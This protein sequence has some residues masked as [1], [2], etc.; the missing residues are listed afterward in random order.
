MQNLMIRPIRTS[1]DLNQART[2]LAQIIES[3]ASG[4]HD[5]EIEVLSTLIEQYEK[6]TIR[7]EA[8]SPV[9][10]IK[11]RMQEMK[12]T[13]RQLE[14]F[15][16]SRARVSEVLSGSRQLS[17]DMIRSLHE[18]LGIP[19]ESLIARRSEKTDIE[20]ISTPTIDRLN[21]WGFEVDRKELPEFLSAFTETNTLAAL[22]RKTRTQRA[23]SRTDQTALL[24]WKAA[25]LKRSEAQ[26]LP[27]RFDVSTFGADV[28]RK[29]ARLSTRSDGPV[30]ALSALAERGIS[31]I[32]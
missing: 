18:G 12:L 27:T 7:I 24:F 2:R 4:A 9:A 20:H 28:L 19:Y 17:I 23:A 29:I 30:R 14:P 10:A 32:V 6:A 11:F 22:H 16:G 13:P 31:V 26:K 1:E 15:I 8:P 5:D 25:V 3:N 21:S